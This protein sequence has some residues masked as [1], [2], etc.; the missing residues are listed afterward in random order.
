MSLGMKTFRQ[1]LQVTLEDPSCT[2]L[3]GMRNTWISFSKM[4]VT[5]FSL[6]KRQPGLK[7]RWLSIHLE[8]ARLRDSSLWYH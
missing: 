6:L 5:I 7:Q 3:L 1:S 2:G 8:W 4:N